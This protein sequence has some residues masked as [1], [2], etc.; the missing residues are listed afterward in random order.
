MCEWIK[1]PRSGTNNNPVNL[2]QKR[3]KINLLD[4]SL[5]CRK[6][7]KIHTICWK[8]VPH[9]DDTNSKVRGSNIIA[10][11]SPIQFIGMTSSL[12]CTTKLEEL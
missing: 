4:C 7:G 11:M 9:V 5:E 2:R 12:D 1:R 8:T 3:C 10:T 6:G